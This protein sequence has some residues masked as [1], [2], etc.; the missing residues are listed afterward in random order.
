MS[1]AFLPD[2]KTEAPGASG[3]PLFFR[4]KP[5]TAA[6]EIP[7]AT[8]RDYLTVWISQWVRDYGIDGFRVDTAKHVD[9]PTLDLLKQRATEALAEWKA[10]N[11]KQALDNAP[12][13]MTGEAWGHGVMKSDYYQHGFD[14][15]I[16]F[17]FQDQASQALGCFSNI[18]ATYQQMAD[19]LQGFNV[20]SYISSHDTRLFFASDAKGS[21]PLQQRAADLLL[22]APGAVQ[23]YYGDESGRPFGPTGSDPLQGTRSDMNWGELQGAKAPLLAHWQ[24]LGQFRERHPAIGA[25]KQQSQQTP[26]YYAF[27]RQYGGDKVMVVWAGD[28]SQ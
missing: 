24:R 28:R 10:A 12:F 25:G 9:K 1:L 7:G 26:H 8:T 5:D 21:L 15:M 18:D 13:W 17:D 2:I 19:K 14:A 23:I 11:P 6:R 22:L 4:H 27:S 20:L 3:L 16:N